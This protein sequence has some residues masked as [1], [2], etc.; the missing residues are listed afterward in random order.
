MSI[1][2]LSECVIFIVNFIEHFNYKFEREQTVCLL[3]KIGEISS[4]ILMCVSLQNSYVEILTLK[5]MVLVGG[6]LCKAHKS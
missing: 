5:V 4:M 3:R 6:G 2:V 1:R